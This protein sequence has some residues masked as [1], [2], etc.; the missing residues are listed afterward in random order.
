[1]VKYTFFGLVLILFAFI[2]CDNS[3]EE[4]LLKRETDLNRREQ[5]FKTKEAEYHSLLKMRDSIQLV[6]D[7][8]PEDSA[9]V[10]VWPEDIVGQWNS[11]I[12]CVETNCNDYIIGDTRYDLWEFGQ[13]SL[14]L[15]VKVFNKR[16][17]IRVYE[18]KYV[19]ERI[20]LD[21][22]T[23]TTAF[24]FVHMDVNLNR[25][26]SNRLNGYRTININGMCTAKFSVELTKVS[27]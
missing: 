6:N 19:D 1:M 15:Y 25:A 4:E 20:Q 5:L 14:D 11:K 7:H 12:V 10:K 3:R 24:R 21:Y 8:L 23:D 18:G 16:D 9:I 2:S 17:L 13:D 27:N 22:S 26:S